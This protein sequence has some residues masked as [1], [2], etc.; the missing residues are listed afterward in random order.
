MGRGGMIET[1]FDRDDDNAHDHFQ[2][3]RSRYWDD[4]FF[5]NYKS[6][7][8]VM[9]HRSPCPHLGDTDWA[10]AEYGF[11]SLTRSKKVCSTDRRELEQWARE[12]T[13]SSLKRCRDCERLAVEKQVGSVA[14][15][16]KRS[17][18]EKI[19]K[20]D[21][22]VGEFWSWAFSD[23]LTN[24]DRATL[25][26]YI[27]ATA[28]G[29]DDKPRPGSWE[30]YD[31]DYGGAKVEVK[32]T[33]LVQSWKS[34]KKS[35]PQFTIKA[36]GRWDEATGKW[37]HVAPERA[38]D[39]YVF[40]VFDPQDEVSPNPLDVD[41]WRFLAVSTSRLAQAYGDQK[42]VRLSRVREIEEAVSSWEL[43]ERVDLELLKGT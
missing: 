37:L 31:L 3:W 29:I 35:K 41:E 9:L 24:V 36:A 28:L 23:M 22:T 38:A 2:R 40:C 34:E 43:R 39:I 33:S 10:R 18:D 14:I 12:H 11:H 16:L 7:N 1:F 6:P 21:R 5:L 25:A 17:P 20:I 13:A 4:G 26:E 32:S 8:N 19:P 42:S 27:V 30:A 15:P